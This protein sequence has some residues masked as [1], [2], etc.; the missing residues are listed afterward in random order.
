M[1]GSYNPTAGE[2]GRWLLAL[3]AV[4]SSEAPPSFAPGARFILRALLGGLGVLVG[5]GK[6]LEGCFR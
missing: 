3:G 5:F 4:L 2:M 1:G 6:G